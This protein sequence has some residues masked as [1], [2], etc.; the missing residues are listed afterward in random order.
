LSSILRALKKLENDPRHLEDNRPLD[1]RFVPLADTRPH[2]SFT[3]II[4]LT[5]GGAIICGLVFFAGWWVYS[6]KNEPAPVSSPEITQQISMPQHSPPVLAEELRS[7]P[8]PAPSEQPTLTI[9]S[10]TARVTADQESS[11]GPLSLPEP[12]FQQIPPEETEHIQKP[13]NTAD[14]SGPETR[15]QASI[16]KVAVPVKSKSSVA[17]SVISKSDI[18]PD[19]IEIPQLN[20]PGMKLQ[21]L[22]WSREPHKR[23]AVINNRIL[24]EGEMVS[25]YLLVTINQDDV[26]LGRDGKIWKLL[27]HTK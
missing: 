7:P 13:A 6:E 9:D 21:A 14:V 16:E 22:T 2:K 27:F 8:S 3:N 24:H 26:I 11:T 18:Q 10:D 25:A 20:D 1:N 12:A 4:L 23:I 15:N 17:A 5:V 19:K